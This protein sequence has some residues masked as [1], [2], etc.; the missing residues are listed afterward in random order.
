MDEDGP[1]LREVLR[2]KVAHTGSTAALLDA[3]EDWLGRQG[4]Q[5][6]TGE[7]TIERFSNWARSIWGSAHRP[8]DEG[9][10]AVQSDA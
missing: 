7:S 2:E 6:P 5:R 1:R 8:A 9:R 3:A 4:L 10:G